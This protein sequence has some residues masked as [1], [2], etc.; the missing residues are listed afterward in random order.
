MKK[1]TPRWV[2]TNTTSKKGLK[3]RLV[4]VGVT[5]VGFGP[6]TQKMR[7]NVAFIN[8]VIARQWYDLEL[9]D[10]EFLELEDRMHN[11]SLE[12]NEGDGRLSQMYPQ[13]YPP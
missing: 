1:D 8:S 9:T 6:R 2:T 4:V 13:L 10:V 11:R 5:V 3:G 12:R 7:E